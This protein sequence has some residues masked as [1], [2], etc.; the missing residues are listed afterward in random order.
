[1]LVGPADQSRIQKQK[2]ALLLGHK[3]GQKL[4]SFHRKIGTRQHV[5]ASALFLK[6][7]IS[8]AGSQ[9][10]R[11]SFRKTSFVDGLFQLRFA[12]RFIL[13]RGNIK[14]RCCAE[15]KFFQR[16][17]MQPCRFAEIRVRGR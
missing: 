5:A 14:N 10:Q 2:V 8:P 13:F 16:N 15:K 7:A 1:M 11:V 6:S 9:E 4:R 3:R 12:D 17:F